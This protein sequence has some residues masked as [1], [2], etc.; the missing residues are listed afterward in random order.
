MATAVR[1]T[2]AAA[3]PVGSG[4]SLASLASTLV[5]QAR[6]AIGGRARV[7]L[8]FPTLSP[9]AVDAILTAVQPT[10]PPAV[11]SERAGQTVVVDVPYNSPA[12]NWP[13]AMDT[14]QAVIDRAEPTQQ[15]DVQVQIEQQMQGVPMPAVKPQLPTGEV[16]PA[17]SHSWWWLLLLAAAAFALTSGDDK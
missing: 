4:D 5:A 1:V 14:V 17:S 7:S 13:S 8:T 16:G 6:P 12:V 9:V 3:S 15:T 2:D 11:T 10:L